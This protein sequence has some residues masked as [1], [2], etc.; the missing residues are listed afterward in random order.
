MTEPWVL[1]TW[2]PLTV[3]RTAHDDRLGWVLTVR[4]ESGERVHIRTSPK[5]QSGLQIDH[6]NRRADGEK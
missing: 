5:G 1:G 2:G 4:D 3:E 6:R